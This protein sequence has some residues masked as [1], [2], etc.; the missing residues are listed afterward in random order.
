MPLPAEKRKIRVKKFL[1]RLSEKS[2]QKSGSTQADGKLSLLPFT[3]ILSHDSARKRNEMML[4]DLSFKSVEIY[5][6]YDVSNAVRGKTKSQKS[7]SLTDK[8][9]DVP[10]MRQKHQEATL[11]QIVK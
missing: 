3:Q 5:F 4:W 11:K 9:P 10:R 6:K 7:S 2:T 1:L 8:L